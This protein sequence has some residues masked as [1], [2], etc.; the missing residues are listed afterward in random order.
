[1]TRVKADLSKFS[2]RKLA[3]LQERAARARISERFNEQAI[4]RDLGE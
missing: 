4:M 2:E 3:H 1:M